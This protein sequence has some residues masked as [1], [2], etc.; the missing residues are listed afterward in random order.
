VLYSAT[1]GTG[2]PSAPV[3]SVNP[4]AKTKD[5]FVSLSEEA[6]STT[7]VHTVLITDPTPDYTPPKTLR[8]WKDL[9]VQ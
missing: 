7:K 1:I 9:R 5:V 6:S 2:I 8:Y 4:T 3:I